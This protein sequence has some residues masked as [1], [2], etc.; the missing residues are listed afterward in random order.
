MRTILK[1]HKRS[2]SASFLLECAK[3]LCGIFVHSPVFRIGG[4]EFVIFLRGNDHSD[5]E[6]LMKKLKDRIHENLQ[7][8]SGP[9]MASGMAEYIPESDKIVSEIF[10]RAD[11]KMYED[12]QNLKKMNSIG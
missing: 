7:S 10:D 2:I 1:P 5:R 3:L 11:K 6:E 12:K 8:G 9:I 4:D